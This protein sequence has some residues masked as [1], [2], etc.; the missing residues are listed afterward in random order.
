MDVDLR[1]LR[2]F[3]AVAEELHFG[4]A[5]V[6]LHIAQPVLSRQIRALE[7]EL[8][9]QVFQRDRRSTELT[10]TGRQLLDDARPLLAAAIALRRRVVAASREGSTFSLGFMPGI[11][12]T[13]SVRAFNARHPDLKVQLVRTSWDDQIEALHDGRVDVSIVRLPVDQRDLTIRPLFSEPRVVVLPAVHRLAG[14]ES[15]K[16]ADLAEEH[17][18]QNPNV[19][20]E[21]RDVALELREGTAKPIPGIHSVEEKLEHVAAGTGISIIPTS[22]A[23]FY[24]RPDVVHVPV[25]DIPPNQ[26]CLAW[27][28]SRQSQV[29]YDFAEIATQLAEDD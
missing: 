1:K 29:I 27:I 2:Y 23:S 7:D 14:K 16:I 26:V 6:R 20:P 5:A 25:E 28:A 13:S 11:T 17:L 15:V 4:R 3:V 9:V 8:H 12:V 19:V 21:W 24:T 22:T 18:L 10:A